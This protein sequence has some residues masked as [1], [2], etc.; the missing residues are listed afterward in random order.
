MENSMIYDFQSALEKI[1]AAHSDMVEVLTKWQAMISPTP[2]DIQ[3][4]LSGQDPVIV[5]NIQKV[6]ETL[7]ERTLPSDPAFKSVKVVAP[8]GAAMLGNGGL[9][10]QS[11]TDTRTRYTAIGMESSGWV[12]PG[13]TVAYRWPL[14][15]YWFVP[16]NSDFTTTIQ[17]KDW[18]DPED[19]HGCDFFVH[20]PE[21]TPFQ[22]IFARPGSPQRMS[23]PAINA[24]A[25][26]HV[27]CF[28]EQKIG[29]R[30]VT[31]YRTKM[32]A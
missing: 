14:D 12:I 15:R 23:F 6:V 7:D 29:G 26:W 31:A 17:P 10:F 22:I 9:S 21:N 8:G 32:E 19:P 5:P 20:I 28:V 24:P 3:F 25:M 13:D 18:G 30:S 4:N 11:G 16:K 1:I 2:Q 27:V